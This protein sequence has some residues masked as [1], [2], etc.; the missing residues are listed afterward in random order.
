MGT[1]KA[2]EGAP[3]ITRRFWAIVIL[4]VEESKV[5]PSV[6]ACNKMKIFIKTA[7]L[8]MPQIGLPA[9]YFFGDCRK[10]NFFAIIKSLL[11]FPDEDNLQQISFRSRNINRKATPDWQG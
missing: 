1:F 6:I 9:R 5:M 8:I 10:I 4:A 2:A 7:F 11:H 3:D